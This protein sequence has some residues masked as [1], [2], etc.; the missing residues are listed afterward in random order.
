MKLHKTS[1]LLLS[2]IPGLCAAQT[3]P[4]RPEAQFPN[5]P[6]W[7]TLGPVARPQ[8]TLLRGAAPSVPATLSSYALKPATATEASVRLL[9]GTFGLPVSELAPEQGKWEVGDPTG[10]NP[11]QKRSL[12]VFAASGAFVFEYDNLVYPD[13]STPLRLPSTTEAHELAVRYLRDN[14]LLPADAR[15]GLTDVTFDSLLV[16]TRDGRDGRVL[17]ETAANLEVRFPRTLDG[18]AVRGPG[19]KL[20]VIFGDGGRIVGVTKAWRDIEG[21]AEA[22]PVIAPEEAVRR[23]QE[24]EGVIDAE[25]SCGRVEVS[26]MEV[27]YWMETPRLE[28]RVALPVYRLEG[29]CLGATGAPAGEFQAYAPAV[30]EAAPT[31]GIEQ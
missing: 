15:T 5:I 11:A 10:M 25:A 13:A 6:A 1:L 28:Q 21:A 4:A 17:S 29:H 23:L 12:S 19:S 27:V 9:A 20:Y 2:L 30:A 8:V 18:H 26:R 22:L 16:S 3:E 7:R 24:G 31:P 14:G